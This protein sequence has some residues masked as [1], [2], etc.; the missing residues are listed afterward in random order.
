MIEKSFPY[1]R[2]RGAARLEPCGTIFQPQKKHYNRNSKFFV[3]EI[4]HKPFSY[5]CLET[6]IFHFFKENSMI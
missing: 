4:G 1:N 5:R 3:E 2:K 6:K